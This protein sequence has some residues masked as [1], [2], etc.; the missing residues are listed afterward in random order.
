[1]EL[2]FITLILFIILWI[3]GFVSANDFSLPKGKI[4]NFKRAVVIFP[5]PDD[6][7]MSCGGLLK[8][9]AD[10][11]ADVTWVVLTKGEKGNPEGKFD[12]DLKE[13]RVK[14]AEKVAE[15]YGVNLVQWDY[16][17]GSV[18]IHQCK[19]QKDLKQI[20]KSANPDLIITYDPAGL[21]G[22]PDHIIVS[23]IATQLIKKEFLHAKLKY[24]SFPKKVMDRVTMPEFMAKDP[25]FKQKRSY[26]TER[27]WVGL[28]GIV[29]KT[30]AIYAYKSQMASYTN[31]FPVKILPLWFYISLTPCEYLHEFSDDRF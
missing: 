23:Q 15:I 25:E 24:I 19:I 11:G 27:I 6:E 4:D 9:L 20:I 28:Q 17:D 30:R 14:E 16:P 26:P 29:T 3:Y 12:D 31:T 2:V 5:H 7:A 21:Y 22:H 8:K 18:D 1:M 10:A 13:I